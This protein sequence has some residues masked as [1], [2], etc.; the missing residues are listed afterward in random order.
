MTLPDKAH[1][2]ENSFLQSIAKQ[3]GYIDR[4]MTH[5][6]EYSKKLLLPYLANSSSVLE[7]GPAEG[8]LSEFLFNN[9]SR[10]EIVEPSKIFA[11]NLTNRFPE[12]IVNCCMIE[13]FSSKE[14]YDLILLSHVLEHVIDPVSV[15]KR[16]QNFM[17]EKTILFCVV[18]NSH[19]IH[20]QAAVT[21]GLLDKEDQL[22]ESDVIHGHKRVYNIR[23]LNNHFLEADLNIISSG[24]YWLKPLSNSQLEKSWSDEMLSAFMTLGESYP[25]ISAEIYVVTRLKSYK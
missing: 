7:V 4:C 5:S 22:N 12:S 24:G 8:Y 1:I 15:L 23:L 16:C 10:Y 13:D 9:S 21:M 6:I 2:S 18:P 20:R 25:E 3:H 11:E 19:S 17:N 14:K